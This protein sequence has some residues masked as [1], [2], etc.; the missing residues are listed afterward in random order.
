MFPLCASLTGEGDDVI[1]IY[2]IYLEQVKPVCINF[3]PD[4]LLLH[5]VAWRHSVHRMDLPEYLKEALHHNG[6]Y[7]SEP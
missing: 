5:Y 7:S 2:L 4:V 1:R 6:T 3:Y